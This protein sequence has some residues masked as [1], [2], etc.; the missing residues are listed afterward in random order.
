MASRCGYLPL[1]LPQIRRH[2]SRWIGKSSAGGKLDLSTPWFSHGVDPLNWHYPVGLLH[3]LA[4]AKGNESS[5]GTSLRPWTLTI[6]FNVEAYPTAILPFTDP[7]LSMTR[8]MLVEGVDCTGAQM[9][10]SMTLQN[11]FYSSLKQADCLRFGSCK[12][13]MNLSK[14]AQIQLWDSLWTRT[15]CLCF[16][17]SK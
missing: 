11:A 8:S 1:L 16:C 9:A 4:L 3:D 2:F 13:M 12:R 17:S 7:D 6:H 14:T 5:N 15:C 10:S